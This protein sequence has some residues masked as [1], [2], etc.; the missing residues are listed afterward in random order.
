MAQPREQPMLIDPNFDPY[1]KLLELQVKTSQLER[2]VLELAR[3]LNHQAVIVE[4]LQQTV[5]EQQRA[6]RG[7]RAL[8]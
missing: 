5:Q 7:L 6:I 3:A 8:S 4:Q 2:N 1:E